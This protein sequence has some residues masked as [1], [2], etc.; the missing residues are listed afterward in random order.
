MGKSEI[1]KY[2]QKGKRINAKNVEKQLGLSPE[3]DMV[4]D[5]LRSAA[6]IHFLEQEQIDPKPPAVI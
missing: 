3:I 6:Y 5:A 4:I 1:E 2:G